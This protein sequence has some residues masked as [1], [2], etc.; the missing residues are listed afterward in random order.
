MVGAALISVLAS[1][2]TLVLVN[3]I[4]RALVPTIA[5]KPGAFGASVTHVTAC[6]E[7]LYS[8][9]QKTCVS[10]QVFD[11]EM[12]RLFSALGIDTSVYNLEHNKE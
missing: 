9:V 5:I 1:A 10:K 4:E 11:A 3:V 6:D 12:Q 8:P 7:G 2:S